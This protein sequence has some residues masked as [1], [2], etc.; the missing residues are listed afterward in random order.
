MYTYL[1]VA[2]WVL[3]ASCVSAVH[4]LIKMIYARR[5]RTHVPGQ[6]CQ[7]ERAKTI[8]P[9]RWCQNKRVKTIRTSVAKQTCQDENSTMSVT[10]QTCQDERSK[11][12]R[13]RERVNLIKQTFQIE[14][15]RINVWG[16]NVPRRTLRKSRQTCHDKR[17]K[18]NVAGQAC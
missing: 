16:T 3:P 13:S 8:V 15:V 1:Y 14:H 6:A 12:K 11:T 17:V 5:A 9:K 18:T 7:D 4:K 2:V 10:K